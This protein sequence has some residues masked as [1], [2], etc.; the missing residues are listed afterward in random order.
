MSTTASG[1]SEKLLNPS[2][3]RAREDR[4]ESADGSLMYENKRTA[5]A[6]AAAAATSQWH[7]VESHAR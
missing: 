2:E 4:F 1:N 7:G 3:R 5:A 6:A